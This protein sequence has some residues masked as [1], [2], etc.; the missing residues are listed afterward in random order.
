MACFATSKPFAEPEVENYKL[1]PLCGSKFVRRRWIRPPGALLQPSFGSLQGIGTEVSQVCPNCI[2]RK[3]KSYLFELKVRIEGRVMQP[4]EVMFVSSIAENTLKAERDQNFVY[5]FVP[6]RE[7]L[8]LLFSTR[9]SMVAVLDR[10][11]NEFAAKETM[12]SK[13]VGEKRDRRRIYKSTVSFKIFPFAEGTIFRY[14]GDLHEVVRVQGH[15]LSYSSKSNSQISEIPKIKALELY[16]R[17]QLEVLVQKGS[18]LHKPHP[19]SR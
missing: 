13:L 17:G 18:I 19:P 16:R 12:S 6:K 15:S 14:G 7:G 2:I 11:N 10:L 9:K 1:C 8:D 5:E 3:N 4:R